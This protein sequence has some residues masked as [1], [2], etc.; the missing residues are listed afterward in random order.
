M[1]I[2]LVGSEVYLYDR[3]LG[4]NQIFRM[5][6]VYKDELKNSGIKMV[7][8]TFNVN[9]CNVKKY[10]KTLSL[11]YCRVILD[12]I[13]FLKLK[14]FFLGNSRLQTFGTLKI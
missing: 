4:V 9:V 2:L 1:S 14:I 3:I 10:A 7:C 6:T 11:L 12:R 8:D 13:S 5:N